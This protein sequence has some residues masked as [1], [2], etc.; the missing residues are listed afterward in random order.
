M[1]RPRH[2]NGLPISIV[3]DCRALRDLLVSERLNTTH[4]RWKQFIL[5]HQIVDVGHRPGT[6]NP[7]ADG[8]SRGFGEE[9]TEKDGSRWSV[10]ADWHERSGLTNDLWRVVE[11]RGDE[12]VEELRMRFEGDGFFEPIVETLLGKPRGGLIKE[13]QHAM[14]R[15][16]EYMI[17]GGRLWKVGDK[18]LTRTLRVECIPS[19]EGFDTAMKVHMDIGH[20]SIDHVKLH[21]Q[22]K[23]LWPHIDSDARLACLICGHCKGFGA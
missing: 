5:S 12:E 6:E 23:F 9:W 21:I 8:I 15:A 2:I 22:D 10:E 14:S 3:T 20:W 19:Q 11:I 7:V 1:S 17:K 18:M 4:S 13:T 16:K